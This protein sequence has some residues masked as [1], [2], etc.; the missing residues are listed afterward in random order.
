MS[1]PADQPPSWQP[2]HQRAAELQAAIQAFEHAA[3]VMNA[4]NREQQIRFQAILCTCTPRFE[5]MSNAHPPNHA[6][7]VIHGGLVLTWDGRWL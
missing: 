2:P 4:E 6:Q 3:E 1:T 7:C 5:P